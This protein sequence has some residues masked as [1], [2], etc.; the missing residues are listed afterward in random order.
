MLEPSSP[1]NEQSWQ[2]ALFGKLR[3]AEE[4]VFAGE[5]FDLVEPD[6][7]LHHA[8]RHCSRTGSAAT[9]GSTARWRYFVHIL[10]HMGVQWERRG[11]V[12][13]AGDRCRLKTLGDCPVCGGSLR[14]LTWSSNHN[15]GCIR[16]KY[17]GNSVLLESPKVSNIDQSSPPPS[18]PPHPLIGYMVT[19]RDARGGV[20]IRN[21]T[22]I[23]VINSE[24][25]NVGMIAI[26]GYRDAQ[27]VELVSLAELTSHRDIWKLSRPSA[28]NLAE[29][30]E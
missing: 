26:V 27:R 9:S 15:V 16:C 25:L 2:A 22:I 21:G 6:I 24:H 28:A 20:E 12:R 8:T 1:P 3:V 11:K 14:K 23:E 10:A 5:L 18:T 7:P 13:H 19:K 4:W 17:I 29:A 30:A